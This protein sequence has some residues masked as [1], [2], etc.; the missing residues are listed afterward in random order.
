MC[1]LLPVLQWLPR[2]LRQYSAGLMYVLHIVRITAS[3]AEQNIHQHKQLPALALHCIGPACQL[4][5]SLQ[6][7][8]HVLRL[9]GLQTQDYMH[10]A[11]L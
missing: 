1:A 2:T 5:I 9:R 6:C 8:L 3:C 7:M 10:E 11:Y 4:V